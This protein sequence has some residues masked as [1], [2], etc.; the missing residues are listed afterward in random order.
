MTLYIAKHLW[1]EQILAANHSYRDLR[2]ILQAVI[3][4]GDVEVIKFNDSLPTEDTSEVVY[5]GPVMDM[6]KKLTRE[7]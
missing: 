5:E 7:V 6:P 4:M 1:A 3:G 2:D